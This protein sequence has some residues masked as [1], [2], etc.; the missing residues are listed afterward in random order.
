MVMFEHERISENWSWKNYIQKDRT[1]CFDD[2]FPC[3]KKD[4]CT[5]QHVRNW[6]DLF[7]DV[8]NN[9]IIFAK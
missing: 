4:N 1:E 3:Q 7:V 9:M 6:F 2:Y 8:H 5:L